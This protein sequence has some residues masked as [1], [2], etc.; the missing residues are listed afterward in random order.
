MDYKKLDDN[1]KNDTENDNIGKPKYFAL[2]NA[3]SLSEAYITIIMLILS[4][5]LQNWYIFLVLC[6]LFTK[7]IPE[8]ILKRLSTFFKWKIGDRPEGAV[9]CNSLNAG[10]EA[11]SSGLVSGHVFNMT[12]L[13]FFLF[14]KFTEKGRKPTANEISLLV[15][16]SIFIFLLMWA[17]IGLKCHTKTQVIIGFL[18]GIIWGYVMLLIVNAI[19]NA[20]PT[21][22][23]DEKRL[24]CFLNG[25]GDSSNL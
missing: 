1:T 7:H 4:I 12:S 8:Q 5:V 22:Q 17:R 18:L 20:V 10:G 3:I 21:L 6:S 25:P 2:M 19:T 24:N 15:I 14:Y 9:N 13:T 11:K 23:N 16:L